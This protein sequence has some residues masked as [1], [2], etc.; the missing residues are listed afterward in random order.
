MKDPLLKGHPLHAMLSDLPVG[1]AVA[2]VACDVLAVLTRAP[3]WRSAARTA[4][5][6]ALVSGSAAALA[7]LWDYQ[8]VPGEHPARRVGALHG[9]LNA[10]ALV[11]LLSSL[12]A[13]RRERYRGRL[14]PALSAMGLLALAYAAWLGGEM[15]FRL[16]WRVVPAEHAEQLEAELRQ[17]GDTAAITRAHET[18]RRYERDHALLP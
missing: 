8:A 12:V 4:L 6:A 5:G 10:S 15:V 9:Y 11:L 7:G 16:G 13:R 3:G 18:V 1:T 2:G 17:R 14:A